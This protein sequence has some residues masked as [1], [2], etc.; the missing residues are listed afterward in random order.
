MMRHIAGA[1]PVIGFMILA[2]S[3]STASMIKTYQDAE[4][5][6][7][8]VR[9]KYGYWDSKTSHAKNRAKNKSATIK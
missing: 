8:G 1:H 9:T 2:V 6:G 4:A 5:Q 3:I 7:K